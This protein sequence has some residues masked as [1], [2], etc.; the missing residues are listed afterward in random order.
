MEEL[1]GIFIG[2]KSFKSKA[3]KQCYVISLVFIDFDEMNQRATYF[4]KDVFTDEKVYN[5]FVNE[6]Q[7]LD[8]VDV[9]REIVGDVVRYYI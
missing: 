7:L 9:K 4:V 3:G 1:K 5:N 6:H 2:F 8:T